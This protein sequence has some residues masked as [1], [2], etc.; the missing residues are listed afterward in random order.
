MNGGL[1]E[2]DETAWWLELLAESGIVKPERLTELRDETNQLIAIFVT[3][4]NNARSKNLKDFFPRGFSV[5][6]LPFAFCPLPYVGFG[7]NA[8]P[9]QCLR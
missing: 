2:L 1:Q 9:R 3:C 8:P 7:T 5:L 4:I 6:F